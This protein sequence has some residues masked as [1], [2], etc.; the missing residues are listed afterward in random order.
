MKEE[1]ELEECFNNLRQNLDNP[2]NDKEID[3]LTEIS[4]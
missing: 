3:N 2:P 1:L 4:L